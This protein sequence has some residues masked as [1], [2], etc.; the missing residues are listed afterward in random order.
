[1]FKCVFL[2]DEH[3]L[4]C[5]HLIKRLCFDM[6]SWILQQGLR[7][8]KKKNPLLCLCGIISV[9][10]KE[11][12]LMCGDV[13][14]P[15]LSELSNFSVSDKGTNNKM[16]KIRCCTS[17]LGGNVATLTVFYGYLFPLS[18]FTPQCLEAHP[19]FRS[20]SGSGSYLVSKMQLSGGVTALQIQPL[21]LDSSTQVTEGFVPL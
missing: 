7:K 14:L 10:M 6:S 19:D 21:G 2:A 5:E 17:G 3:I 11:A 8:K 4:Y 16:G 9:A 20:G 12:F 18:S 1:M 15:G 13:T